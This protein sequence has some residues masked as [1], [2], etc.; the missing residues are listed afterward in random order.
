MFY[1]KDNVGTRVKIKLNFTSKTKKIIGR[2]LLGYA[3]MVKFLLGY[4]QELK[5]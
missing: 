3:C 1:V 5:V 4:S 2:G